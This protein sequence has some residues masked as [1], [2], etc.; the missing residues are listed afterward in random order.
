MGTKLTSLPRFPCPVH[1][2]QTPRLLVFLVL[3]VF[4]RPLSRVASRQNRQHEH[5]QQKLHSNGKNK[6]K[7]DAER[8]IG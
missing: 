4:S 6:K 7:D 2:P 3:S 1:S 8:L 5:R